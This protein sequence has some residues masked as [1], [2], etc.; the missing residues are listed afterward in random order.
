LSFQNWTDGIEYK[1]L[2]LKY[3]HMNC[4]FVLVR[5][6]DTGYV[7]PDPKNGEVRIDYVPSAFD[8]R[9]SMTGLVAMA[10]ILYIQGAREIHVGVPGVKPFV[11]SSPGPS[12]KGILDPE[13]QAWL[14]ELQKVGLAPPG[15][16]W[17]SAHQMGTCRMSARERDGVVD[18]QGKVWGTEGLYVADASV[19]PSASGVNPMITNMAISD[20]I[21]R[22]VAAQM[23]QVQVSAR[24]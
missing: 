8:R 10:K 22:G 11:S 1:R 3:R 2:A 7:Y 18:P 14:K 13:L 21:S 9:S 5:D 17:A 24:L 6:K 19:F 20:Y 23:A 15:P 12:D 16:P 4:Y